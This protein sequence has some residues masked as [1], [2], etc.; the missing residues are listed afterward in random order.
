MASGCAG[1]SSVGENRT[2]LAALFWN[3]SDKATKTPAYDLYADAG[4]A[5]RPQAAEEVQ[6]ASKDTKTPSQERDT[7][8]PAPDL[9]AQEDATR[10]PDATARRK[11][12][13]TGDTSIRVTLGRPE[14]LP[15]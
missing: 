2:G 11:R 4:A 7:E 13:K 12:A 1:W 14:S 9:V 15:T 5:A 10:S 8:E 3:R 6:V